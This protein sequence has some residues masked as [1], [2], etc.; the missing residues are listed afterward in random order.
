MRLIREMIL[1]KNGKPLGRGN[2]PAYED[3]QWKVK[4]EDLDDFIKMRTNK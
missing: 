1:T 3:R 2:D 4:P